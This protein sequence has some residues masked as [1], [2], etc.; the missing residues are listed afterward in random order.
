M[1]TAGGITSL[2]SYP[3]LIASGLCPLDANV[4]NLVAALAC[5]PGSALASRRELSGSRA[6]LRT[7]LPVA[8]IGGLAGAVALVA[9][10]ARTF[11]A[12][13]PYLVL[14]G[15]VV[16]LVQPV[17]TRRLPADGAWRGR[18]VTLPA[19]GAVS[20]YGGYLGAGAL[21]AATVFALTAPVAWSAVVPLAA[22]LFAGSTL[23]PVLARTP[24]GW[25]VRSAS[26]LVGVVLAVELLRG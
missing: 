21:T 17:V 16:V 9:T 20:V 14:L 11:P 26:A 15:S 6:W 12:I 3:A 18:R 13:A 25:L 23:G 7:A 1:G 22:G 2:V 4:A 24:P 19:V 5:W 8:A 10:P